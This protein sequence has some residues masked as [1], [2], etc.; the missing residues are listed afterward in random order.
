MSNNSPRIEVQ[1]GGPVK[2][3]YERMVKE[4]YFLIQVYLG[5]GKDY[6]FR[7]VKQDIFITQAAQLE[8]VKE[9]QE[10]MVK[11]NIMI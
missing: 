1:L 11:G 4:K 3:S 9:N 6:R 7:M 8:Q 2:E 10:R 5:P